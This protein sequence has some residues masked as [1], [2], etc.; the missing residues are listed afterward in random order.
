M[1]KPEDNGLARIGNAYFM[2]RSPVGG[3]T[4][5]INPKTK[6]TYCGHDMVKLWDKWRPTDQLP[7]DKHQPTCKICQRHYDDPIKEE[8]KN[9]VGD[10][11]ETVDEYLDT[12]LILKDVEGIGRF[13]T[14]IA[15]FMR[16]E[17]KRIEEKKEEEK[18]VTEFKERRK[19]V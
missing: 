11:K 9:L 1:Q 7:D 4:H 13:T 18:F 12:R 5:A 10:L 19:K 17:K 8:L 15:T 14:T 16:S 2:V 6:K 3:A